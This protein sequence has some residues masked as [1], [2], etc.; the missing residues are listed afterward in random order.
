MKIGKLYYDPT[1]DD[2]IGQNSTKEFNEYKYF[3]LP[4]DLLYANRFDY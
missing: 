1:F 3:G 4:K 2:P